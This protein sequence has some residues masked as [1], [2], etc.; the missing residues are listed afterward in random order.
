[1]SHR[2]NQQR[3]NQRINVTEIENHLKFY[4]ISSTIFEREEHIPISE[5]NASLLTYKL[6]S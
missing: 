3:P 5:K 1:M 4:Y 6:F 2:P